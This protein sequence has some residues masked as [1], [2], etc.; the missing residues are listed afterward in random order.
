MKFIKN[1]LPFLVVIVCITKIALSQEITLAG[2]VALLVAV[3]AYGFHSFLETKSSDQI[4]FLQRNI[5][6]LSSD[7][8]VIRSEVLSF[9]PIQDQVAKSAEDIKKVISTTNLGSA[10]YQRTRLKREPMA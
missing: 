9:K 2:A 7:I 4:K 10:I 5:E 6:I 8:D 1:I 3:A